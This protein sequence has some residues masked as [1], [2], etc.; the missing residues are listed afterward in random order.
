MATKTKKEIGKA[1]M[2]PKKT[3]IMTSLRY[4]TGGLINRGW[5]HLVSRTS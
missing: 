4:S 3:V 2:I 1:S 5:L